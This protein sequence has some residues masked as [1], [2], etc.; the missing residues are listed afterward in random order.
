[1]PSAR[2]GLPLALRRWLGVGRSLRQ[3]YGGGL[4]RRQGLDRLHARFVGSGDLAFDIGSHVGDR[5]ASLRRLGVRVVAVEPQPHLATTLRMLYGRDPGVTIVEAAIGAAEGAMDLHLNLDNPTVTTGSDAFIAAAQGA[6]GWRGQRWEAR[7]Q[8]PR[9][10][11]DTLVEHF[12]LPRFVKIDVEGLEAAVL[13]G[14]ARPVPSLSFEF[15]TIQRHIALQAL[16]ECERLGGYRYNA[17]LGESGRFVHGHWLDAAAIGT[18]LERLPNPAN[19]GDVY[20]VRA[21]ASSRSG[22][23]HRSP[24]KIHG[25]CAG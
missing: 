7:V 21:D 10:T 3:Y 19:S 20:A 5:I 9:T 1:M 13:R 15:T 2:L 14:L 6:D 18:W 8:V 25:M 24:T 22:S 16:A 11:L 4:E 23:S 17:A 12:G